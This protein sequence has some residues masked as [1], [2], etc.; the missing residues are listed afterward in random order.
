M[1]LCVCFDSVLVIFKQSNQTK[2]LN[3]LFS[4]LL[5]MFVRPLTLTSRMLDASVKTA[6][7]SLD[8]TLV[9]EYVDQDLS[10]YLSKVPASG[11]SRE[12][13]EV[14]T[15]GFFLFTMA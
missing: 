6:G 8:L 1:N 13:V 5:C 2:A 4:L 7:N 12:S 15:P 10:T 3:L 14:R 11:L 9:L